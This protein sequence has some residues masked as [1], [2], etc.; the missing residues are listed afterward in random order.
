M[1]FHKSLLLIVLLLLYSACQYDPY[2]H[3]YTTHKP[4]FDDL[5]GTYRFSEQTVSQDTVNKTGKE[6]YIELRKNGTYAICD[7][8][9]VFP[10]KAN[11]SKRRITGNISAKGKWNIESVGNVDN[12]SNVETHWG[13]GL[14]NFNKQYTSIGLMGNK[15]P[16][17]I[18]ITLGD[19]DA[20]EVLIFTRE[21]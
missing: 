19:P 13:I 9:D 5:I 10:E 2:A 21:E 7:V 11:S 15:P 16:Y 14:T 1:T 6:S 4:D 3:K 18:I 12:G 17:D 8:P 20:G